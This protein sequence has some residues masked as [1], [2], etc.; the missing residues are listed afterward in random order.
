MPSCQ[1]LDR[2]G[3]WRAI[4]VIAILALAVAPAIPL[5]LAAFPHSSAELAVGQTFVPALLRG[6][7]VAVTTALFSFLLGL[8]TGVLLALHEF[9]L[10]RLLAIS[11]AIALVLPPFLPALG[12]SML[13]G[14]SVPIRLNALLAGAPGTV[15]SLAPAGIALV[16]FLTYGAGR[17]ITRSQVNATRLCDG[18]RAVLRESVHAVWPVSALAATLAGIIALSEAGPGLVF[19]HH[20]AATEILTSFSAQYDFG[21]A[22]RQCL[23]LTIVVAVVAVPAVLMLA[24][25]LASRLL[26]R[27]TDPVR[28]QRTSWRAAE[29]IAA[30][31]LIILLGLP[32]LGLLLPLTQE[33][34]ASRAL[35]EIGRTLG[36]TAY[37]ALASAAL[38]VVLGFALALATSRT[39]RGEVRLIGALLLLFSLPPSFTALGWVFIAANT[40]ANMDFLMR[41]KPLLAL[42]LGLHSL[43]IATLFALRAINAASASWIAAATLHGVSVAGYLRRVLLP[44]SAPALLIA[45]GLI[46]LLSAADI[47]SALLLHPPGEGTV[48][49]TIFT[50]MANAPQAYIAALCLAYVL[51]AAVVTVLGMSLT[52]KWH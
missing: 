20:G 1:A 13:A 38:A 26:A 33:F 10:R 42:H 24:P 36:N 19:G 12:L 31:L 49:L 34:P 17:T 15:W 29:A 39:R 28:P 6:A 14:A 23:L 50:V 25:L 43:P 48:A 35:S 37:Y 7:L 18:E 22:A 30:G 8:P 4:I 32:L 27:D 52:R 51:G 11:L 44:W 3:R 16:T 47:P 40:P 21:Q 9:P 41:D 2:P 46:A 5:F 45:A